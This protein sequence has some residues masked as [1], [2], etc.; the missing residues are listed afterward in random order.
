MLVC[1]A[2]IAQGAGEGTNLAARWRVGHH[3]AP[4]P[5]GE[6]SREGSC[7]AAGF[8]G[9]LRPPAQA[10]A[11]RAAATAASSPRRAYAS[12]SPQLGFGSSFSRQLPLVF[13]IFDTNIWRDPPTLKSLQS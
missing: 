3:L 11:G 1:V 8:G 12:V 10:V 4:A 13:C 5:A 9:P 7:S 6:G 2:R